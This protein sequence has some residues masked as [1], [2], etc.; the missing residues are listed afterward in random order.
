MTMTISSKQLEPFRL[1]T[2][3]VE[4]IWGRLDLAP[5][6]SHATT[7]PIGEAWLTGEECVVETG[8]H[9]G[10]LLSQMEEEFRS[11]LLGDALEHF[12]L[13]VKMLFPQ[14][15]LSVQVHPD[16]ADAAS[17]G[18]EARAKTECWYVLEAEPGATLS[19]GVKPGTT[20]E[21]LRNA[22]GNVALE[23]LLNEV[24]VEAGDMLFIEAGTIHAI[25]GGLVILE[26]QQPSDTT[27]RLY[28]YGRPRELHLDAG[29]KVI[30]LENGSGKVPPRKAEYWTGLIHEKYFA[31]E[32][33]D[34]PA[35]GVKFARSTHAPEC[36]VG[37]RGEG[38]VLHGE[39]RLE[40]PAGQAVVI[41]ACCAEYSVRGDCSFVRCRIPEDAG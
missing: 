3:F 14:E 37:L 33:C 32:R 25:G 38:T 18:G 29:M 15:K 26:V 1:R 28:D 40:L 16:D 8:A 9:A 12:P 23:A 7:K 20:D 27:F 2:Q 17:M 41:P 34:V 22:L 19:I 6:Y 35:G 30:K 5:W 31:V 24:P 21:I 13:L 4:R 11:E 36:V 39:T 10:K